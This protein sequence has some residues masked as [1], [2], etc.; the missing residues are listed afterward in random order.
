MDLT[1]N[2]GVSELLKT[3]A[4]HIKDGERIQVEMVDGAHLTVH[5]VVMME[6]ESDMRPGGSR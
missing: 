6:Q 1:K 3:C 5:G 4:F 2:I